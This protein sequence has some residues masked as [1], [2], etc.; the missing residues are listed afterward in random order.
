MRLDD[1]VTRVDWQISHISIE[2]TVI[3]K[4]KTKNNKIQKSV[5]LHCIVKAVYAELNYV[6]VAINFVT[7][8]WHLRGTQA[9]ND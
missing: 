2:L 4:I 5:R 7:V 1:D 8:F 3:C 6:F 9:T